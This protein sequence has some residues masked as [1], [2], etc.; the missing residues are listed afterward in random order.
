VSKRR[1]RKNPLR[2]ALRQFVYGGNQGPLI[3]E[4]YPLIGDD[5]DEVI[6]GEYEPDDD[7]EDALEPAY[8][9]VEVPDLDALST[10]LKLR[11]PHELPFFLECLRDPNCNEGVSQLLYWYAQERRQSSVDADAWQ[12]AAQEATNEWLAWRGINPPI[13]RGSAAQA[14]GDRA[15]TDRVER[16]QGRSEELHTEVS[17]A[18]EVPPRAAVPQAPLQSTIRPTRKIRIVTAVAAPVSTPDEGPIYDRPPKPTLEE[19]IDVI[20][21]A[22]FEQARTDGWTPTRLEV[23]P[24]YVRLQAKKNRASTFYGASIVINRP[25]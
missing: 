24:G 13:H 3:P 12:V 6:G 2:P 16:L 7:D 5:D 20:S 10:M 4:P 25:R 11:W 15:F 18:A 1:E 21:A 9:Y 19:E 22:L 23:Q 17:R 8:E 14:V